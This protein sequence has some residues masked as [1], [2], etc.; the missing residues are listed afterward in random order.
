[1]DVMSCNNCTIICQLHLV[2]PAICNSDWGI[3]ELGPTKGSKGRPPID[4]TISISLNDNKT[5]FKRGEIISVTYEVVGDKKYGVDVLNG[6]IRVPRELEDIRLTSGRFVYDDVTREIRFNN[7]LR[8][9]KSEICSYD[10]KISIISEPGELDLEKSTIG[11]WRWDFRGE[12]FINGK[13]KIIINNNIPE[14]KKATLMLP[15]S[16]A[17]SFMPCNNM[18]IYKNIGSPLILY[19]DVNAS[20][21]ENEPLYCYWSI[22]QVSDQKI[23]NHTA[24]NGAIGIIPIKKSLSDNISGEF[25]KIV[26]LELSY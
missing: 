4:L 12:L 1:M 21:V 11:E 9:N 25:Y 24:N 22:K 19:Y 3:I 8:K 17:G 6:V 15:E 16:D 13:T 26:D 5:D 7:Y 2:S 20:D 14:I 18:L 10:A 23:E